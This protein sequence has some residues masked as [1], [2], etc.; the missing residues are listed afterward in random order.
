MMEEYEDYC[1]D[2]EHFVVK[3][4][5]VY[6]LQNYI[7]IYD[8]CILKTMSG[9]CIFSPFITKVII[10]GHSSFMPLNQDR[11]IRKSNISLWT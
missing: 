4:Y 7:S 10:V 9:L 6:M 3:S 11:G 1:G 2:T 5:L 8:D